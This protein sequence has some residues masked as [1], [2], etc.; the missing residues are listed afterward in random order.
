MNPGVYDMPAA[1]YHADPC[2]VPS[3]S[4]SI[5]AILVTRSPRHAW[6]AHPRLNPQYVA[7]E[8]GKFD[9]GTAAHE[10]LL[11]GPNRIVTVE[12]DDW[13]TKAAREQKIAIRAE[14][15]LPLLARHFEDV[16]RMVEIAKFA[17]N[18]CED[19]EGYSLDSGKAEQTLVWQEDGLWFRSR[20]DWLSNDR[21]LILDYKSTAASAEP[22][23]WVRTMLGMT[24]ELQPAFYLRGNAATG[25]PE[26]ARFV[27]V[28]QEN[29]PPYAVSFVGMPP[30]FIDLGARKV[31]HA[32]DLWHQCMITGQWPAYPP[33]ICWADPPAYAVVQWEEGEE[34]R[35]FVYDPAVLFGV[36]K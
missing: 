2:A 4:S 19:L 6:Q 29:E 3:L 10:M 21:R 11:G 18:S 15:K 28:V 23:S 5:A 32:V 30:A 34:L 33:R 24:G 14:G 16:Q 20:L 9:R 22:N 35:G 1:Q 36:A 8:D 12:A 25:G 13:R 31:E 7:E 27:F 17:I 26:D